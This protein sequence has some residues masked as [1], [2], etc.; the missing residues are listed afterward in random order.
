MARYDLDFDCGSRRIYLVSLS[1]IGVSPRGTNGVDPFD[2]L[3]RF[4]HA[5]GETDLFAS[6]ERLERGA[7][8]GFGEVDLFLYD[9]RLERGASCG[10]GEVDLFLYDERLERGASRGFGE[11]DLF[12]RDERLERGRLDF[13]DSSDEDDSPELDLTRARFW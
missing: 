9:E 2:L 11:V 7:S 3:G 13:L 1:R 6:D 12:A 5:F 8:R 10:F 4:A